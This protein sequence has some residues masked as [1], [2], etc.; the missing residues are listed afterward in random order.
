MMK[1]AFVSNPSGASD[2]STIT[3]PPRHVTWKRARQRPYAEYTYEETTSIARCI[4]ELVE[5]STQDT[6]TPEGRE[7]I[8]AVA[9]GRPEHLDMFE[10]LIFDNTSSM[11]QHVIKDVRKQ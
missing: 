7:D 2:R 1:E 5:Q 4:D 9:I 11:E 8:L 10:V 6:F 3:R